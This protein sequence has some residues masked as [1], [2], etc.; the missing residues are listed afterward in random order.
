MQV[1]SLSFVTSTLDWCQHSQEFLPEFKKLAGHLYKLGDLTDSIFFAKIDNDQEAEFL[2][3]KEFAVDGL[4]T[5]FV[6]Q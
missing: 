3:K 6:E 1:S 2:K 5:I 4:P